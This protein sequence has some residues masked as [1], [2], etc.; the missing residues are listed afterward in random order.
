LLFERE[1]TRSVLLPVLIGGGSRVKSGFVSVFRRYFY[2]VLPFL[3]NKI[4]PTTR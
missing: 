1:T 2:R 3:V 4:R